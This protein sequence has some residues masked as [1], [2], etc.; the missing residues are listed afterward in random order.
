[1]DRFDK[2]L[3]KEKQMYSRFFFQKIIKIQICL[4]LYMFPKP[5][6]SIV[7]CSSITL[8]GGVATVVSSG[9]GFRTVVGWLS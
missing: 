5:V 1:L 8:C 4:P 9:A 3:L 2:S 6:Q 7:A